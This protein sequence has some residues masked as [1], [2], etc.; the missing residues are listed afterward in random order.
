MSQKPAVIILR[1]NKALGMRG[2]GLRFLRTTPRRFFAEGVQVENDDS[3][4]QTST[5][6]R[7][8]FVIDFAN[9]RYQI[10]RVNLKIW[11]LFCGAATV[12]LF[13]C[14]YQVARKWRNSSKLKVI[15]CTW[16]ALLTGAVL[17][18]LFFNAHGNVFKINLLRNGREIEVY[19]L[20]WARR[21][22]IPIRAITPATFEEQKM[23]QMFCHYYFEFE[24]NQMHLGDLKQA[25]VYV[26]DQDMLEAIM[27]G[28]EVD[29]D[30]SS[31]QPTINL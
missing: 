2:A 5:K 20:L 31:T 25:N 29:V 19:Q 28:K 17:A 24:G 13:Y 16:G 7:P 15:L 9:D 30:L 8:P 11:L 21:R 14:V 27:Q 22:V 18:Y 1:L 10:F 6:Y 4:K 3:Q 23:M 12:V 26:A